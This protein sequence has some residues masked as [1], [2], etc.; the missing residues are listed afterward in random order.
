MA[1]R[2]T[3]P[4]RF[5]S[6][7]SIAR[8][9]AAPAQRAGWLAIV[10]VAV[11]CG[12]AQAGFHMEGELGIRKFTG[13]VAGL[14]DPGLSIGAVLVD[15]DDSRWCLVARGDFSMHPASI[16]RA[17]QVERGI[18][19]TLALG[20]RYALSGVGAAHGS[21]SFFGAELGLTHLDWSLTD[22]YEFDP[23][24]PVETFPSLIAFS[25]GAEAGWLQRTVSGISIGVN[26]RFKHHFWA[27]S[28]DLTGGR[29]WAV[30]GGNEF[31]GEELGVNV[32]MALPF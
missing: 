23:F 13:D 11:L 32:L 15:Q 27:D 21:R 31:K 26:A 10:L 20:T 17:H 9:V 4:R 5:G 1:P 18:V 25:A 22:G 12:D 19:T 14:F 16:E 2:L 7:L 8:R 29:F 30:Q 28:F 24:G 6:A 3:C